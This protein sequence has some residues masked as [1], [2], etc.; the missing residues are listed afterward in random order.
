MAALQYSL[1]ISEAAAMHKHTRR[2]TRALVGSAGG[3]VVHTRRWKLD[4]DSITCGVH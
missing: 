1:N 2:H 3:G 4:S